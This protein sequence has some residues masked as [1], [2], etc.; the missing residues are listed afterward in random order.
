VI[1]LDIN[2]NLSESKLNVLLKKY[3][4]GRYVEDNTFN[5]VQAKLYLKNIL[6]DYLS[7]QGNEY[8]LASDE[9]GLP[10]GVIFYRKSKWDTDHFGYKVAVIDQLITL[11]ENY[12][13][14]KEIATTLLSSFD[15]WAIEN[16]VK[17]VTIKVPSKDLGVLHAV[18]SKEFNY[19]ENWIYNHY[20]L[21]KLQEDS[22]GRFL[23]RY[24]NEEDKD[25]MIRYSKGAFSTQRFHADKRI[26]V[27]QADRLYEKWIVSAF[28]DV[29]Q[30]IAVY[31]HKG[32]PTAFMIYYK[33][34]LTEYFNCKFAM[35]KMGLVN[36]EMAHMGI[37]N[38][39]VESLFQFHKNE[40]LDIIDSGLSIRNIVS[41]NWH[42]KLKFKISSTLVTFHKWYF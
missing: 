7:I 21:R 26:K 36:P 8:I 16:E 32:V 3:N 13:S 9:K 17:F 4:F 14:I 27:E 29:N 6:V 19:I 40:N 34:D 33:S 35:W 39:F 30:E 20:D 38:K 37:G 2:S 10:I 18:E 23:I 31:D 12:N 42:N 15:K 22:Q 41:L 1:T 28:E 25:Y 5:S 24:A 11:Q